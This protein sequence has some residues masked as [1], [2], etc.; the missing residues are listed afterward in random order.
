M[1]NSRA[2]Y[3]AR[4][5]HNIVPTGQIALPSTDMWKKHRRM[6]AP[7]LS[8]KSLEMM[9]PMVLRSAYELADLFEAKRTAAD[10]RPWQI[11]EDFVSAAMVGPTCNAT[12]I[13]T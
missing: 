3:S 1:T 5:F 7:A 13:R 12:D 6:M 9:T 4:V 10:G 8:N 11:A 2:H